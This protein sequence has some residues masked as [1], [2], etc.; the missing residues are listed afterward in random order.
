MR[1]WSV[2]GTAF[3]L[4]TRSSSLSIRT[5]TSMPWQSSFGGCR[6]GPAR[7]SLA[8]ILRG[9][10]PAGREEL[11]EA[12]RHRVGHEGGDVAA[13]S[14]DLLDPARRDE[15]DR[16]ARHHVDRLDVR[17]E[18]TVQLVHLELPFEVRDHAQA[19]DDRLR[20]PF[21]RELDDELP[22]DVDLDVVDRADRVP[23]EVDP[24]L[25][26]EHR[27]LVRRGT[28]DADDDAVEDACRAPDHVDVPVGHRV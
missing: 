1:T 15:A 3:A 24:L 14:G 10:G 23:E 20:V 6:N 25:D 5:S 17:R 2:S 9:A 18:M 11:L 27:L 4:W 16:R 21:A 12:L 8:R 22:E 26:R 19:L 13:E 7:G 28:D